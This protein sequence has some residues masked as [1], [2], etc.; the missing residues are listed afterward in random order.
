MSSEEIKQEQAS[1]DPAPDTAFVREKIK[2]KPIN[3]RKLLRRTLFTVL[4]AVVF[5]VVATVTFL[6]LEPFI[7]ERLNSGKEA[8]T[9]PAVSV[10][11][12]SEST[13]DE[14]LPED[15]YATDK[16]MISE[17]LQGNVSEVNQNIRDIE[18]MI[19]GIEFGLEDYQKLY[20]DLR[21]LAEEVSN[22]LVT[23]KGVTEETDLLNNSY[24]DS[25]QVSGVIIAD[26]GPS[27][28]I[29][30]KDAGLTEAD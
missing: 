30:V 3:R 26:N 18:E 29:L 20:G 11:D 28:L 25:D 9:E 10:I 22:S 27:L 19:S 4:T 8:E 24:E 13:E 12:F 21:S 15:M 6:L 2:Q 23:V 14:M 17:A 1:F 16:E 7:S 5:A